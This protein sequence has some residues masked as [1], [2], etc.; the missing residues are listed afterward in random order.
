M[1]NNFEFKLNVLLTE[2]H[3]MQGSCTLDVSVLAGTSLKL[4]RLSIR[5]WC[6]NCVYRSE[7]HQI[8]SFVS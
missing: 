8:G 4:N 6:R 5:A 7:T 1:V 3:I 2:Y